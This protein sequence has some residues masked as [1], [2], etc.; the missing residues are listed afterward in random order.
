MPVIFPGADVD[1]VEGDEGVEGVDDVGWTG[2]QYYCT[3]V[4]T[5]QLCLAVTGGKQRKE[6]GWAAS[7]PKLS[8]A[9]GRYKLPHLVRG[10]WGGSCHQEILPTLHQARQD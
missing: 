2:L 4:T 8:P 9:E 6:V 7:R 5:S 1:G 3:R 10:C